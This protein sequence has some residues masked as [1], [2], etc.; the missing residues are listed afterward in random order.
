MISTSSCPAPG[1]FLFNPLL[2]KYKDYKNSQEKSF[3]RRKKNYVQNSL[4]N[5]NLPPSWQN[6]GKGSA[7]VWRIGGNL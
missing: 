1:G 7:R 4:E 5:S 3:V 2:I 6:P